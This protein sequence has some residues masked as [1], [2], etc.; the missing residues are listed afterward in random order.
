M[1]FVR[2]RVEHNQAASTARQDHKAV[3]GRVDIGEVAERLAQA[4]DLD[5]QSTL[6]RRARP[7]HGSSGCT[8]RPASA[9][10]RRLTRC[11]CHRE[12]LTRRDHAASD[13]ELSNSQPI[14]AVEEFDRV[15]FKIKADGA[16]RTVVDDDSHSPTER[17]KFLRAILR[18]SLME[19]VEGRARKVAGAKRRSKSSRSK[20][21]TPMRAATKMGWGICLSVSM[22]SVRS[23]GGAPRRFLRLAEIFP[24]LLD[25][26]VDRINR[27]IDRNRKL[28]D[29]PGTFFE[30]ARV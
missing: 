29:K 12:K 25:S 9:H 30:I 2:R 23:E 24:R 10:Q 14:G 20:T 4:A 3:S 17:R 8:Q 21:S 13:S 28:V 18:S 26:M 16:I 19:P 27:N 15:S 7:E 11:F 6:Q 1:R 5:A 22:Y